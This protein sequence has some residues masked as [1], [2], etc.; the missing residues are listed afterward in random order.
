MTQGSE[1]GIDITYAGKKKKITPEA[2]LERVLKKRQQS[3][4]KSLML[5]PGHQTKT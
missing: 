5:I 4:M 2:V 1:L 3:K